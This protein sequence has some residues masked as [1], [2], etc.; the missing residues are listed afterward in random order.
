MGWHAHVH[1]HDDT[2]CLLSFPW[3]DRFDRVLIESDQT[4]PTG[5][6]LDP[7]WEDEDQCWHAEVARIDD[8]VFVAESEDE[9]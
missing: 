3:T 9:P 1:S 4:L 5:A 2:V 7:V 8:L 6:G